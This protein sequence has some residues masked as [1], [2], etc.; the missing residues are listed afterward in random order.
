MLELQSDFPILSQ[1]VNGSKLVYLDSA[2]TAQKP[3]SVIDSVSGYYMESNANVHRAQHTLA[4]RA[5]M[6][7]EE[8]RKKAQAFINAGSDREIVFTSGT[9]GS[10]NLVASSYGRKLQAGDA[11]LLTEM[12]HHSNL[13]PWQLVAAERDLELL[14]IPFDQ[15]GRLEYHTLDEIWHSRIKMVA[16]TH[17]SNLFGTINDVARV[18][19]YAHER[20]AR[21][22]VD[23]AQAVPHTTVDVQALDCDFYAFSGHKMCGPTG[24]GALYGKQEILDAMGPYMGGGEMISSVWLDRAKWNEIPYKFEAGTPNIAGAVGMGSAIDYLL[25]VGIDAIEEHERELTVYALE[26]LKEIEGLFLY[27]PEKGRGGVFS[28]NLPDIHAH[29]V[30]QFLDSRGVAIRAGHH[31]AHPAMRKLGVTSTARASIYLYN[32]LSDIDALC[33]ALC[34]CKEFFN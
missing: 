29:D 12:E 9:T 30:A 26:K 5:T 14:F 13:I 11:V 4:S 27:G 31:C 33:E 24:I 32:T 16:L 6:A 18:I 19:D 21:V 2:A 8:A 17:I 25:S 28:F 10:I 1:R 23:G 15:D 3:Q 22:L 20:G 7:Y 34:S